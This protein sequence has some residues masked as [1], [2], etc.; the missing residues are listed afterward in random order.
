LEKQNLRLGGGNDTLPKGID[1]RVPDERLFYFSALM[2]P[3]P[4][5]REQDSL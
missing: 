5:Y 3:D 4:Q 2:I 1:M